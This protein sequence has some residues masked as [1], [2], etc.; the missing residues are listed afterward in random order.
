MNETFRL[1]EMSDTDFELELRR[2]EEEYNRAYRVAK[3]AAP[4]L[5]VMQGRWDKCNAWHAKLNEM[6]VEEQR[7]GALKLLCPLDRW[8]D[9]EIGI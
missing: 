4:T 6:Q 9:Q 8:L 3:G 7:R 1:R 2:T 5:Q